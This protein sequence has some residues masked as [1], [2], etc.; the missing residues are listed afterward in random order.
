MSSSLMPP[1]RTILIRFSHALALFLFLLCV[2]NA[3]HWHNQG[4]V[5]AGGDCAVCTAIQQSKSAVSPPALQLEVPL[6][7]EISVHQRDESVSFATPS[8]IPPS[9]APPQV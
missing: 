7:A 6:I 3:F 4:E 2:G 1:N 9:R 8:P 5:K